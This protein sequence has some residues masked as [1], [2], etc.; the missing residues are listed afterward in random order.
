MKPP[1]YH[2]DGDDVKEYDVKN[3]RRDAPRFPMFNNMFQHR[4]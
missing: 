3:E 4:R 2:T 1:T